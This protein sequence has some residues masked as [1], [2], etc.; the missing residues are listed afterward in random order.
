MSPASRVC[1]EKHKDRRHADRASIPLGLAAPVRSYLCACRS[2]RPPATP[3]PPKG[4]GSPPR[5]CRD[6]RARQSR[7]HRSRDPDTGVARKFDLDRRYRRRC[8]EATASRRHKHLSKAIRRRSQIPA[9][10]V[11]QARRH[12]G[13]TRHLVHHGTGCQRRRDNRLLLLDAPPAT[14]LGTGQYLARAIAPSLAPV[15]TPVF[16]LVL[17]STINPEIARRSSAEGYGR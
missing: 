5:Q 11:D 15:Q 13:L 2:G 16:A 12:V 1:R 6:D 9:P 8:G 14:P 3:A 7:R 4:P 17:T 10:T